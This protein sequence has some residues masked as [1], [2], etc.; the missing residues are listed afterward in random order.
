VAAIYLTLVVLNF[1]WLLGWEALPAFLVLAAPQTFFV[2]AFVVL[3]FQLAKALLAELETA[4]RQL[5]E[6]AA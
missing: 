4:L 5:S 6:Y 1:I 2:I 3:F